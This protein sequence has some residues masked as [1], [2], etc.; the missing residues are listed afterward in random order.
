MPDL[1]LLVIK[2]GQLVEHA[3]FY[4]SLVFSL[5]ITGMAWGLIIQH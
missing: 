4:A 3:A 2:T 1:N 5:I